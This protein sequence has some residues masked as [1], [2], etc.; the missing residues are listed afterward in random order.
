MFHSKHV[1]TLLYISVPPNGQR[2]SF[3]YI[4]NLHYQT[5]DDYDNV[6]VIYEDCDQTDKMNNNK[7][8]V[9]I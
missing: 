5:D 2:Q 1:Y 3:F 4:C 9:Q 7:V 6:N 8:V